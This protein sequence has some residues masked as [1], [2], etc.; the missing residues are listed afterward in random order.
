RRLRAAPDR[1]AAQRRRASPLGLRR[2]GDRAMVRRGGLR[3][4]RDRASPR[5]SADG[6][7]VVGTPAPCGA[8]L[9]PPGRRGPGGGGGGLVSAGV[10]TLRRAAL[11]AADPIWHHGKRPQVSFEFF[12]PKTAEMEERLWQAVKRLE[13]LA[14][15]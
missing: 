9:A 7:A 4:R 12:P 2:R 14:P 11:L 3:S 8:V 6:D 1:G 13:P 10:S 15:R 5:Q